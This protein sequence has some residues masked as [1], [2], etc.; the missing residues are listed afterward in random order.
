[1]C[2]KRK[3]SVVFLTPNLTWTAS[4]QDTSLCLATAG[5]GRVQTPRP[6]QGRGMKRGKADPA[7][8]QGMSRAIRTPAPFS[9]GRED[10]LTAKIIARRE[11]HG[12]TFSRRESRCICTTHCTFAFSGSRPEY[13][14]P[15]RWGF[16]SY[17]ICR[18][19]LWLLS[20][21][22]GRTGYVPF[23]D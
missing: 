21:G 3:E 9:R 13:V 14:V 11:M 2:G 23:V 10:G 12:R 7:N 19:A 20:R 1:M 15:R 4:E 6:G 5:S 17:V 16:P 18:F 22:P 8:I